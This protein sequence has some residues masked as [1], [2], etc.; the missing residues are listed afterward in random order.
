MPPVMKMMPANSSLFI[1]SRKKTTEAM[2][3]KI[4]SICPRART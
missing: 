2:K 4:S 3:V 1:F